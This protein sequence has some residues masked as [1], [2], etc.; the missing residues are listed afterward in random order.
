MS[1]SSR[2][3][4][5]L[6][7]AGCFLM[8]AGFNAY[9]IAPASVVPLLA[10]EFGVDKAAAGL[11][12]SVVFLGWGLLG[13]PGGLVTDRYDNRLLV[14]I[15]VVAFAAASWGGALASEYP[16]FLVTR[17]LGGATG[18]F[19]WTANA[20]VVNRVF[21]GRRRAVATSAFVAG[22]PAGLA[23]AQFAGPLVA[24]AASWRAA[25]VAY[26]LVV[27]LGFPVL[28]LVVSDPVRSGSRISVGQFVGTL[29]DPAILR[30]SAASAC[31]YALFVFL[32]SWMPTYATEVLSI[33]LAAAGAATSLV[34]LSGVV[35]R[36]GGGWL[37][38]RLGDRRRPVIVAS[39]ASSL[40]AV[41][42]IAVASTPGRFAALL[43]IAGL[44]AQLGI[45]LFYVYAGELAD[46]GA[47]GTSLALL[48]TVSTAGSLVAPAVAGWLIEAI[49]WSAGFGF[50]AAVGL[51][52]LAAISRVP[53]P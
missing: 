51:V 24:E 6:V 4:P 29:R 14:L 50:A 32:N 5:W 41:A 8:A 37:S 39:F 17:F 43:V 30:L 26:P 47:T 3:G 46:E 53:E 2:A 18:V 1:T 25:L 23:F 28:Y 10:A 11:S 27:L 36:P 42:A 45:G 19:L 31:A 21:D 13:L 16:L 35:A 48:T 12:I 38:A 34:A 40:A 33:D 9:I 15:G 20:N 22:A 52:G 7:L 44:C 49:S